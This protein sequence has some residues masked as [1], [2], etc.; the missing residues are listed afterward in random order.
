MAGDVAVGA[1]K[2]GD[3]NGART[4]RGRV[5]AAAAVNR[6]VRRHQ[7]IAAERTRVDTDGARFKTALDLGDVLHRDVARAARMRVDAVAAR[8]RIGDQHGARA[9]DQDAGNAAR[10]DFRVDANAGRGA[11]RACAG[12]PDAVGVTRTDTVAGRRAG[13]DDE[14][15]N[16]AARSHAAA[17]ASAGAADIIA[18]A[19]DG[20][21]ARAVRCRVGSPCRAADLRGIVGDDRSAVHRRGVDA[22]ACEAGHIAGGVEGCRHRHGACAGCRAIDA[23]GAGDEAGRGHGYNAA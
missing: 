15:P 2:C 4:E 17:E 7:D 13:A 22:V 1:R 18:R 8:G 6:A 11:G 23:V 10:P 19:L 16:A 9:V 5:D 12:D 20:D 3:R 21:R 14:G